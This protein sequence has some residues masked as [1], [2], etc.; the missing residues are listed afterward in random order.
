M[1]NYGFSFVLH[2]PHSECQTIVLHRK[3]RRKNL[4][5]CTEED[6]LDVFRFLGSISCEQHMSYRCV[7]TVYFRR[8]T[9]Q[10]VSAFMHPIREKA[11]ITDCCWLSSTVGKSKVEIQICNLSQE[12][13]HWW[14]SKLLLLSV[15]GDI[16]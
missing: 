9:V 15:K 7:T 16:A 12:L 1:L 4:C 8:G 10:M 3:T 5:L 14:E 11:E 2:S 13:H 6:L